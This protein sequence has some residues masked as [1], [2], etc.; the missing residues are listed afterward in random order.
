MIITW[1]PEAEV[2]LNLAAAWY[3]DRVTWLG[4]RFVNEVDA[5]LDHLA[6]APR[7]HALLP[8]RAGK[9]GA[10]RSL[11]EHFPFALI[12]RLIGN[13]ELVVIALLHTSR[14]RSAWRKRLG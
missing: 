8:G 12:Y 1:L 13:D 4:V 7:A 2:E 11:V 3:E 5:L 10:R 6:F 9:R 14:S